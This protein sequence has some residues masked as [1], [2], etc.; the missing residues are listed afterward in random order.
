MD[1]FLS[2]GIDYDLL[3]KAGLY[4]TLAYINEMIEYEPP[5][6]KTEEPT[7]YIIYKTLLYP[8]QSKAPKK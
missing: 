7:G 5:K 4:K 1:D 6:K 8:P 3:K 2:A